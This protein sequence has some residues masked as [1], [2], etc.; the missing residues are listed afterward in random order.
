VSTPDPLD[1]IVLRLLVEQELI[2]MNQCERIRAAMGRG[3][4]LGKALASTP[5]VEPL[6]FG[7][8]QIAAKKLETA[9][10]SLS[11]ETAVL[12][13]GVEGREIDAAPIDVPD[14]MDHEEVGF[15]DPESMAHAGIPNQTFVPVETQPYDPDLLLEPAPAVTE[16]LTQDSVPML[17][18]TASADDQFVPAA[19]ELDP[20]L[21]LELDDEFDYGA[22]ESPP[23]SAPL[24]G[25]DGLDDFDMGHDH[26]PIPAPK[27]KAPP[28]YRSL[29]PLVS[30]TGYQMRGGGQMNDLDDHQRNDI[31]REA[32]RLVGQCIDGSGRGLLIDTRLQDSNV[33]F[34]G[35][36][37][38]LETTDY[39]EA[40]RLSRVVERI[41]SIAGLQPT[42]VGQ[43]QRGRCLLMRSATMWMGYVD[44]EPVD[45][46]GEII[47]I[48][49]A[50]A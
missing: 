8:A 4:S 49:L 35:S 16:S 28:A 27:P 44:V 26:D 12:M 21:E 3:A 45:P 50:L 33:F 23:A 20:D 48:H 30:Q 6:K 32:N 39:L 11:T 40:E 2:T 13:M 19:V 37:Y 42:H 41:K 1:E 17:S 34:F 43:V 47:T 5:L 10:S 36:D 25:L 9:Q 14:D 18:R 29:L 46:D 15:N 24:E 22:P 31:V 7:A 38:L